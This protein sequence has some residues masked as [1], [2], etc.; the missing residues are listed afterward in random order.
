MKHDTEA[1]QNIQSLYTRLGLLV[2]LL[3]VGITTM[4]GLAFMFGQIRP[5]AEETKKAERAMADQLEASREVMRI[6]WEKEKVR[7]RT[8]EVKTRAAWMKDLVDQLQ[9][10]GFSRQE[11]IEIAK[12]SFS[13]D[14]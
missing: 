12:H 2:V 5:S 7:V 8:Y 13:E 14:E 4:V 6:D 11:A 9:A 1:E 10:K 3:V